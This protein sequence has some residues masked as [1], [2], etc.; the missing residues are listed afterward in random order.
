MEDTKIYYDQTVRNAAGTIIQYIYGEDGIDAT[1]IENQ[2][3]PTIDMDITTLAKEYLLTG[4]DFL[5][6]HM[7]KKAADATK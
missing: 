1:K 6:V 2:Y 7:N 3:V 5:E 4:A